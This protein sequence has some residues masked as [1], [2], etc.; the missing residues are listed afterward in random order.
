ML[1]PHAEKWGERVPPFPH[2]STPVL[3]TINNINT[4]FQ[5]DRARQRRSPA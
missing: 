5:T 4:R 2:R 1:S 3:E